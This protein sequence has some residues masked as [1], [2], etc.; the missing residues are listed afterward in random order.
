MNSQKLSSTA[1]AT[2]LATYF[3]IFGAAL[4]GA[5]F[6][7]FLYP[8]LKVAYQLRA[9]EVKTTDEGKSMKKQKK[10]T[11]SRRNLRDSH[12]SDDDANIEFEKAHDME[13]FTDAGK[14]VV[15]M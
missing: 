13:V 15:K 12:L 2:I 14:F 9:H 3:S 11:R 7:R 10:V 8:K 4:L 1:T 5:L 6:A